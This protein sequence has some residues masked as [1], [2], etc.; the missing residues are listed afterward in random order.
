[1]ATL[2]PLTEEALAF[3]EFDKL[4]QIVL[5]VGMVVFCLLLLSAFIAHR[6]QNRFAKNMILMLCAV[7]LLASLGGVF[8]WQDKRR[9][10]ENSL[11]LAHQKA[12]QNYKPEPYKFTESTL[13]PPSPKLTPSVAVE[14]LLGERPKQSLIQ[15][16]CTS[17]SVGTA[18]CTG[19]LE[20]K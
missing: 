3:A 15:M 7:Q 9:S 12:V 8:V 18:D 5:W 4:A 17:I 2:N 1:M 14:A 19:T 10:A 16:N 11:A 20:N 13:P 6:K